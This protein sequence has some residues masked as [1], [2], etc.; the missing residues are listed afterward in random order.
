[1]DVIR[2]E[3]EDKGRVE[4]PGIRPAGSPMPIASPQTGYYGQP[5]LKEPQWTPLIPFYFVVGGAS[6]SLGVIGSLADIIGNERELARTARWMAFGGATLSGIL[7]VVDL[8][9]PMRFLN[10]LRV[11]KPQSTMS[12]GSWI[13]SG[14]SISASVAT[15]A[16]TLRAIGAKGFLVRTVSV[17]GRIGSVLF[18]MPF[19]NY[20]GVLLG[21]TAV[22]VW[23]SYVESLPREFGMSGLQAAV[24]LLE[25]AGYENRTSLNVLGLLSAGAESAEAVS[26][27]GKKKEVSKPLK[28]GRSGLLVTAGA[29]LSGPVAL[30]LRTASIFAGKEKGKSL[31]R[32]AAWSGIMGSICFR[33]G[34]VEAGTASARDWRLPLEIK[35]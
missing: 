7:L 3:A 23:N 26:A 29:I 14:F 28:R 32:M 33:Y 10:M 12:M 8:G 27:M 9:R 5:M 2:R 1:L 25:L 35:K 20:T 21:T 19:H 4:L 34:W 30:S 18:G 15:S 16:D 13:F 17:L 24:S 11:F 31:R 6:G 22:P